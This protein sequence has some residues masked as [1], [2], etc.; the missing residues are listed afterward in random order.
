[1]A[2]G[3]SKAIKHNSVNHVCYVSKQTNYSKKGESTFENQKSTS[4]LFTSA[5]GTKIS[6]F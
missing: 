1:M 2:G 6:R 5:P 3:H 4:L